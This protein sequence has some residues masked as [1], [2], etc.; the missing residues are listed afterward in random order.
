MPE[1]IR[2][3]PSIAPLIE[4]KRAKS[5]QLCPHEEPTAIALNEEAAVLQALRR[6]ALL[7]LLGSI[8]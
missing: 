3:R 7:V 8:Y 2:D 5:R 4:R 1:P 6:K